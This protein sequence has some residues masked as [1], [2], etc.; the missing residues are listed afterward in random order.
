[1]AIPPLPPLPGFDPREAPDPDDP[2]FSA[3][4]DGLVFTVDG[5]DRSLIWASLHQSPTDRL[6]ALQDYVDTFATSEDARHPVR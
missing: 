5:V 6:R 1:M 4:L 2:G 3:W